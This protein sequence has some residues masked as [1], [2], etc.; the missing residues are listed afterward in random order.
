MKARLHS[1]ADS[2]PQSCS[3]SDE[4]GTNQ[5]IIVKLEEEDPETEMDLSIFAPVESDN[6]ND[7]D[8]DDDDDELSCS[9]RAS[10]W[11]RRNIRERE[12]QE[13]YAPLKQSPR[14][15]LKGHHESKQTFLD[16]QGPKQSPD[17][18]AAHGDMNVGLPSEEHTFYQAVPPCDSARGPVEMSGLNMAI[19]PLAAMEPPVFPNAPEQSKSAV[20]EDQQNMLLEVLNYCRFLHAAVQRLE[21]KIDIQMSNE[22]SYVRSSARLK[23]ASKVRM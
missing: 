19:S 15:S 1:G 23:N 21:Q 11:S 2:R 5:C 18:S 7:D 9:S 17:C 16:E 20:G 8:D 4:D 22:P 13:D 10:T 14:R 3:K 6:S 12:N